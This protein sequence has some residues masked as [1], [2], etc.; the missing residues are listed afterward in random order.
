MITNLTLKNFTVF[1]DSSIDFSAKINVI[2]G[3]NGTGKS[4]LLK[5]AYSLCSANNG[6]SNQDEVSDKE[7]R[8]AVTNKLLNV[9]LPPD[10]KLGK[11]RKI[12]VAEDARIRASFNSGNGIALKFHSNSKSITVEE[13]RDYEHYSW[14]PIFIPTKE[15]LTF[16][17][18]F[19]NIKID[20]SVLKL[21]FDETY[22]DLATKLLNISD[23][24]PRE[25]EEWLLESLVN[26]M[27]GRFSLDDGEMSFQPGT[28]IEYA[29]GKAKDG[30]LT[31]FSQQRKDVFSPNMMAEGFRKLGV[32]Q[33]LLQN[34]SLI[35][36]VSGP[37]FWDEPE[38]N[39]NPQLMK[40]L[41]Q[42]ILELSR[43]NQQIILA[44]HDYVLLKWLDLLMDEGKGD[45]VRFHSLHHD[46]ESNNIKIQSDDDYRQLNSNAIA[47]TFSDLYDEEIK[48]SLGGA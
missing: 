34:C 22:F 20:T 7:I 48:R 14:S 11:M 31:Y 6:L 8:E 13:N 15:I 9:F 17:S 42:S 19:G 27:E 36:G 5:A 39:L 38:S 2:I 45:H 21:M 41:V 23:Q 33:G 16:L 37:L 47:N 18:G 3:E 4:H 24:E 40:L 28:Y 30:K 12:G 35:P 29:G 10:R 32:L 46:K 25:K 1:Q 43:S 44:T 26:K